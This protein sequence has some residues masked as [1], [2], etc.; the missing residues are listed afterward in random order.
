MLLEQD[1]PEDDVGDA[2]RCDVIER[3]PEDVVV[4][5]PRAAADELGEAEP[6]RLRGDDRGT[7]T[8]RAAARSV[9]VEH[10]H[11]RGDVIL[12]V[13]AVERGATVFAAAPRHGGL[14]TGHRD[15]SASVAPEWNAPDDQ[16]VLTRGSLRL[17]S[18]PGCPVALN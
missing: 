15:P 9:F 3:A 18:L 8:M 2:A 16:G 4:C 14:G 11:H 12:V 10:R 6:R 13:N 7:Q 1:V 17:A 5:G